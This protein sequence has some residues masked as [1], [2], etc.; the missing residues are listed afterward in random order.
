MNGHL[1][2]NEP[3]TP[4]ESRARVTELDTV[5]A[6]V[7]QKYFAHGAELVGGITLGLAN[8]REAKRGVL[9]VAGKHKRE[10]LRKVLFE[11]IGPALPA[12]VIRQAERIS[13]YCDRDAGENVVTSS[14]F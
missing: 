13:I 8:L 10:I 5:T 14:G 3:G 2:L 11:E 12:T 7:G 4:F 1:A 9:M 6:A